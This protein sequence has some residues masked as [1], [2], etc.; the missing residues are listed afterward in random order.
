MVF[1][2]IELDVVSIV[3][4]DVRVLLVLHR[5][6]LESLR[7]R[8]RRMYVLGERGQYQILEL[9]RMVWQRIDKVEVEIAQELRIVFQDDQHHVHRG[10]VETSHRRR[11]SLA[12]HEV[13]LNKR[14]A[15][16]QEV[17]HFVEA[18]ELLVVHFVPIL[19]LIL[20]FAT[21]ASFL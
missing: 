11:S 9:N 8:R 18:L 1:E 4:Q 6:N 13:N 17:F 12:R 20:V 7:E 5:V 2:T 19:L 16:D 21:F 15:R 10:R 14:E 3:A